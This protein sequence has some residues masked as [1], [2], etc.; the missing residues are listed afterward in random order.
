MA[1]SNY[2]ILD[3]S[4]HMPLRCEVKQLGYS[5]LHQHDYFEIDFL[6]SGR[7]SASIGDKVYS[8]GPEDIFTVDAHVPHELRS[9]GCV[10]I[11]VQFEQSLFEK[12]LPSPQH[13]QFFC[14][15]AVQGDSAAFAQLRRLIARLVKNNADRRSGF[16]LRN[17]SLVYELM[18]TFYNNFR[19]LRTK[20]QDQQSHRYAARIAEI[21]RIVRAHYTENFSLSMLAEKVH[22]SA[23]YL[24]KFFDQQFGMTF[25]AYLTQ[26]RLDH[27]VNALAHSDKTIDDI[28]A[29]S[30]FA[31]THSFVQAFKK[32]YDSLP[33]VYR[34]RLRLE[35]QAPAPRI[36]I[37]QHDHMAGLKKYLEADPGAEAPPLRAVSSAVTLN[38][39]KPGRPLTHSWRRV[40]CGGNAQDLLLPEVQAVIRRM[41][42]EIGFRWIKLHNVFSDGM[43]VCS[44]R[45]D[46][47][48]DCR[49]TYLDL[50]LDFALSL[51]LRPMLE[52]SFM[53]EALA[54][55]PTRRLFH[56]LVSE[57]NQPERWARL[58]ERLL[59]HLRARYGAAALRDW[60]FTVWREPDTPEALFGFSSDEAFFRF[61]Q[62]TWQTVKDF[63]PRLPFGAPP[64]FYLTGTESP[65]WYLGFLDW[66]KE[67]DCMPD[68]LN[69]VFYDVE[70]S[71]TERGGQTEF[72]FVETM[73]L[74]RDGDGMRQFLDQV[75]VE[76][77]SLG[78]E[79]LPIYLTEWN[80]TPSQQDLLNDTCYRSCYLAK[81]ILE[82]YDRIDSF[83]VW[84]VTDLMAESALPEQLFFGGL[85]LFTANG[86]PKAAYHALALLSRLGDELLDRGE[87]WFATRQGG[88]YRIMLYNYRHFSRLYANGE[89]FDMTFTDRYTPFSPEQA[90][91]VHLRLNSVAEGAYTVRETILNRRWGSAFDKWVEMGAEEPDSPE[92]LETL[93]A[94]STPMRS[95]YRLRAEKKTL[96][97]DAL[98]DP[99]ELR[100]ITL[101]PAEEGSGAQ[102]KPGPLG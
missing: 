92:E 34:R 100:L 1:R 73:V 9:S 67:H 83:G 28:A 32:E 18:D 5:A 63:D 38:A 85:G 61:Y 43:H 44:L 99:L 87:G 102:N 10:L 22:L 62:L 21:A 2:E 96:A 35:K 24:S 45:P 40:L 14:N 37:E 90:L 76:R 82:N 39:A 86:V 41:Q 25:L 49:F 36:E 79:R 71:E 91:D 77:R 72:G 50:A 47:T 29:D 53:P 55:N 80:H 48:L 12:T 64:T 4:S 58:V 60:H 95:K 42:T 13:P 84:S 54:K 88:E 65:L 27:A 78:L 15:S 46:G 17:L 89:R 3:F 19:I 31:N 66:C 93:A 56:Y 7:L 26:I 81:S 33:S 74:R 70:R 69:F 68:D 6:L 57:P 20:A 52:L 11:T 94:L 16:E 8:L 101:S 59:E 30:G 97:I 23:P 98:L 51:G 75:L